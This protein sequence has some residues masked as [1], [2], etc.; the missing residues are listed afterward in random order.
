MTVVRVFTAKPDTFQARRQPGLVSELERVLR[1]GVTVEVAPEARALAKYVRVSPTKA[2]RVMD[3]VRGKYV[4]EALAQLKFMPNRGARAVEKVLKSAA[5]NA[6]E[7]WGGQPNEL[8]ISVMQAGAGPTMKRIQP[9][10]M[11]RAYRILKR[12]SHIEVAVQQAPERPA[13]KG[14]QRARRAEVRR[15]EGRRAPK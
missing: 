1:K 4:D 9:R 6:A 3:S 7:G 12:S 2:Q 10:A 11:G 13:K 15:A 14:K 5:A 8:K